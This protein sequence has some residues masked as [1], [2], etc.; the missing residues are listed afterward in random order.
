MKK[1]SLLLLMMALAYLQVNAALSTT[2][3]GDNNYINEWGQLKLN[4]VQL[5]NKCGNAI[6]LRGWATGDYESEYGRPAYD[7]KSDLAAMKKFGANVVRLTCYVANGAITAPNWNNQK[8]WLKNAI[9]WCSELGIY[10]IVDYHVLLEKDRNGNQKTGASGNPNDYLNATNVR[11]TATDF[12]SEISLYVKNHGYNHVIY[13][14]CN[15]PG[16]NISWNQIKT[17]ADIVLPYIAANDPDAVVIVGTGSWSQK[18]ADVIN[19][20]KLTHSTLQIMYTF[21]FYSC[22]HARLLTTQFTTDN[23]TKLPVFITEW[24]DTSESGDGECG[25]PPSSTT[26]TYMSRINGGTNGTGQKV[27]WTSWKWDGNGYGR[28]TSCAL[29]PVDYNTKNTLYVNNYNY[30][31]ADLTE[32]GRMVYDYLQTVS[33]PPSCEVGLE[34]TANTTFSIYPNPAK[35]GI[36]NIT[37]GGEKAA[38]LA[39]ANLQ[40]QTVYST[41]IENGAAVINANLLAGIYVVSVQSELG[42]KTQKLIVK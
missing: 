20:G 41:T 18:L 36:F 14:I 9:T 40:G 5:S 31:T 15:E 12:F 13:E 2:N 10:C 3:F 42:V 27:S 35:D 38:A 7:Q 1:K 11:Q 33:N 8:T 25:T 28:Q 34:S 26:Q 19:G 24:N 6:Q 22:T 21:H 23:L 29:N 16:D 4:G 32:R 30:T 17:Y 39:I 37:L